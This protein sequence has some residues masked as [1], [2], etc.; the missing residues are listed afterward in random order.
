MTETEGNE[1][2]IAILLYEGVEVLDFSGPFE[3]LTTAKRVAAKRGEAFPYTPLLVAANRE[4]VVARAGYRVLPDHDYDNCPALACLLVP[5]GVHEPHL[6]NQPLIDW[7][8][9]RAAEVDLLASVC[10]GAFLL[11]EAGL[12]SGRSMTTHWEDIADFR[13]R[14]TDVE[15]IEHVRWVEDGALIS[16]AGISAGIDMALQMVARLGSEGLAEQT[17]RQMDFDWKRTG[18]KLS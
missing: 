3:V 4:P 17:A 15:I 8:K 13:T 6:D 2:H 14:Y 12:V 16:S 9:R 18:V 11:A 10:T 1:R 5:G 7:V